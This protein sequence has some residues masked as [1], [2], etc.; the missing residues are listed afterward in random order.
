[1]MVARS[2]ILKEPCTM[3]VYKETI[4]AMW[5]KLTKVKK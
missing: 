5:A 3:E 1:M 2:A 4:D